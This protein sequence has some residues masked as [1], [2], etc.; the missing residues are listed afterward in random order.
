MEDSSA[1]SGCPAASGPARPRFRIPNAIVCLLALALLLLSGMGVWVVTRRPF[2]SLPPI[3]P[4][5]RQGYKVKPYLREA[6]RL[7]AMGK[8][9]ACQEL[10]KAASRKPTCEEDEQI[11]IL[12]RMLFAKRIASE[13]RGP[14]IGAPACLGGT[15][16][17][18][19]P[20]EPIEI[21]DGVPFLVVRGYMLG[22]DPEPASLYLRYCMTA[23]DWNG[24]SYQERTPEELEGALTKILASPRWKRA[25]DGSERAFLTEQIE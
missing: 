22:G 15:D 14:M 24:M 19:W 25:L 18:D 13:F 5:G 20:L 17:S 16:Y 7:Q 10:G 21:M 11:I 3:N 2:A 1:P 23:C 6:R 8:E 12:C 4:R 9:A